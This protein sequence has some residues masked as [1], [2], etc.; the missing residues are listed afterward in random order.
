VDGVPHILFFALRHIMPGE[1]L[2]FDYGDRVNT[3]AFPWLL[4]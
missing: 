4:Q 2:C 1:E 3:A